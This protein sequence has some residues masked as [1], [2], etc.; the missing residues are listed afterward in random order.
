MEGITQ[1]PVIFIAAGLKGEQNRL[2]NFSY[3]TH[4]FQNPREMEKK[5][6]DLTGLSVKVGESILETPFKHLGKDVYLVDALAESYG[7]RNTET[8]IEENPTAFAVLVYSKPGEQEKE[9]IILPEG[10]EEDLEWTLEEPAEPVSE[11]I[12]EPREVLRQIIADP[13]LSSMTRP[14]LTWELIKHFPMH[15]TENPEETY[16]SIDKKRIE[17][18]QNHE[19][20]AS[21]LQE[22]LP[23]LEGEILEEFE[24]KMP[25]LLKK[26]TIKTKIDTMENS[27]PI[28]S[29]LYRAGI[30]FFY[31]EPVLGD[32]LK[33]RPGGEKDVGFYKGLP[34]QFKQG[35]MLAPEDLSS[36]L[37]FALTKLISEGAIELI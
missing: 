4:V 10:T 18:F 14:Q 33:I 28:I 2:G 16:F 27:W 1:S 17:A 37:K 5:L 32:V 9:E 36:P 15:S 22:K 7:T 31:R 24:T 20:F 23:F 12:F 11:E 26:G 8:I 13:R 34:E 25:Q 3:H 29:S 35:T 30:G 19:E 21:Y 6:L